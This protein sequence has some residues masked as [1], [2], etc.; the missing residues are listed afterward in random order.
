MA[1]IIFSF[2]MSAPFRG[3]SV[4][5]LED[6][7]LPMTLMGQFLAKILW[8]LVQSNQRLSSMTA[9]NSLKKLHKGK[10]KAGFNI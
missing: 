10:Y 5:L 2:Q 7:L 3:L 9:L 8:L 4:V 6:T 1:N